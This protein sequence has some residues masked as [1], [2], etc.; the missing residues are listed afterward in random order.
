VSFVDAYNRFT[1][2]Y[3]LKR[4]SDVFH[5]FIEYQ[6]HVERLLDKKIIHVQS[7]WGGEYHRLNKFFTDLC[8]SHR[9][10]CPHTHQHNGSAERKHRHIVETGLTL[11]A[12]ASA[13]Y[14]FWGDAFF[15]SVFPH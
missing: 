2:L 15:H 14:R 6:K 11:L 1:W 4:K 5:V 13:P 10:S 3:L 9:V 7:D 12:H 8:I